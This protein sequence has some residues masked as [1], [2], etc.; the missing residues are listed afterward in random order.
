MTGRL[1]AR[2]TLSSLQIPGSENDRC[3]VCQELSPGHI[4]LNFKTFVCQECSAVHR[5]FGH[6]V[7]SIAHTEWTDEELDLIKRGGNRKAASLWLAFWQEYDFPRPA[8]AESERRRDF[9]RKAYVVKCWQR[10]PKARQGG[11]V[12]DVREAAEQGQTCEVPVQPKSDQEGAQEAPAAAAPANP[13]GLV[14]LQTATACFCPNHDSSA[15]RVK[16]Q[17]SMRVCAG[18]CI[19]L[20]TNYSAFAFCPSCSGKRQQ[21]MICGESSAEKLKA[22]AVETTCLS[23]EASAVTEAASTAPGDADALWKA[24]FSSDGEAASDAVPATATATATATAPSP[25]APAPG[26]AQ[27]T[28]HLLDLFG[29]DIPCATPASAPAVPAD[30]T[31]EVYA[32]NPN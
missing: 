31:A 2:Q 29:L 11:C 5:E 22:Q 9:I 16:Q 25:P 24:D 8:K 21:C 4:C 19:Q 12:V 20:Q 32:F 18:C 10:Q 13:N 1:E 30:S 17:P 3:A 7:A 28:D 6:K 26:P 27:E 14:Y 23:R 15:K